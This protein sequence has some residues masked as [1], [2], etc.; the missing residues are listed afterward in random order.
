M[1]EIS[2]HETSFTITINVWRSMD[3]GAFLLQDIVYLI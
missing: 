3:M 1:V 2:E